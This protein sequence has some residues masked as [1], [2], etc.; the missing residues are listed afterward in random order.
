MW[1]QTYPLGLPAYSQHPCFWWSEWERSHSWLGKR[2][3]YLWEMLLVWPNSCFGPRDTGEQFKRGPHTCVWQHG[4]MGDVRRCS[5]QGHEPATPIPVQLHPKEKQRFS[6]EGV[7]ARRS[8]L[9]LILRL[10]PRH[11]GCEL[12]EAARYLLAASQQGLSCLSSGGNPALR[13]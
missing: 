12:R 4:A 2:E 9:A 6:G 5:A 11:F 13:S 7:N 1:L 8:L 3:L 10:W